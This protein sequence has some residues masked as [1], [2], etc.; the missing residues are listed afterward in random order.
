MVILVFNAGKTGPGV[1]GYVL[2][3]NTKH[4]VSNTVVLHYV[5]VANRKQPA[6]NTA[7]LHSVLVEN[8]DKHAQNAIRVLMAN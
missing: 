4:F 8:N 2:A 7:V 6:S 5:L 1:G 3:A